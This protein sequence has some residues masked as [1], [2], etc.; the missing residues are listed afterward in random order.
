MKRK[1]RERAANRPKADAR[2]TSTRSLPGFALRLLHG[3]LISARPRPPSSSP[4]TPPRHRACRPGTPT[5]R[6]PAQSPPPPT[7]ACPARPSPRQSP[8]ASSTAVCLACHATYR[9]RAHH[10]CPP[11]L[12]RVSHAEVR[13][14]P[15]VRGPS[16]TRIHQGQMRPQ[17]SPYPCL[18]PAPTLLKLQRARPQLRVCALS[19][20]SPLAHAL[21]PSK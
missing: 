15:D 4:R 13:I 3:R 16:L 11:S 9:S 14:Y 21:R 7:P 2:L 20:P 18:R 5:P 6:S 8:P 17:G 19:P 1:S 10:R 12:W